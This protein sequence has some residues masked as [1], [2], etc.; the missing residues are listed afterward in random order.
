[1][2][3]PP[4]AAAA[5]PPAPA[6]G[7]V[8]VM[9]LGSE[10]AGAA[11]SRGGSLESELGGV[12]DLS[13]GIMSASE[14]S[15]D[16]TQF[17]LDAT[18][19]ARIASAAYDT[20][21]PPGL[22]L[23]PV[24]TGAV[25]D[26][27]QAAVRRADAA[28]QL[29]R[30]GLLAGHLAG[31]AAYAGTTV[32]DDLDGVL[33]ADRSGRVAALSLGSAATLPGRVRRLGTEHG[34]VVGDL[35]AGAL[36]LAELRAMLAARP[37]EELVIV[38]QRAREGSGRELLWVAAAGLPG[39]GG[40]EL[41]SA[42]TDQRGLVTSIDLAPTIL[43][44]LGVARPADIRGAPIRTDGPLHAAGLGDLMARLQVI[45]GRR[46]RALGCLLAAWAL[47]LLACA[48]W[49]SRRRRAVAW[50]L[51]AGAL[52]V[53]WVPAAAL[54]T[55]ALEPGAALEYTLIALV[56]LSLGAATDAL[57]PWPR[58][59]LGPT[60]VTV[61]ALL[62]DA[63]LRTQLLV[64]SLLGPDPI[65]G[66]RFYGFGNELKSALAVLVFAAVAA[67][68][69]PIAQEAGPRR[70]RRAAATMAGAGILLAA[71]VGSA[72]VG[73]G[74]GGVILVCAGT[75]VAAV[76]LLPGASTRRR[77][78]I[79]LISPLVGLVA[80]AALDLATAHGSGHFTGSVLHARSA[81]DLRDILVR[82]YSAAWRELKNHAMPLATAL[83]LLCAVLGTRHRARLLA[84]VQADRGW[85]AAF[86]GGLAAGVVGAFS[87]DSGPVLF[88]VAVFT[89]ACVAAYLWGGPA[90]ARRDGRA[91]GV[92]QSSSLRR[93]RFTSRTTATM[94]ITASRTPP[95]M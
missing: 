50:A 41:T 2:P 90:G 92:R 42:T 64:R 4:S 49:P 39:G 78:L 60:V 15:Y 61:L 72:R 71:I 10:G 89:L 47:V 56:C 86:A 21:H 93:R 70:L 51:R 63:L 16:R 26:G 1:M 6:G 44:R 40:R 80:L 79:V 87:E 77:M 94:T 66:A 13:I 73:A 12:P 8:L 43:A 34:L 3:C 53:L 74:V 38:V 37:A 14:G 29:L 5:S 23:V 52:G 30:P 84:P 75:A 95:T 69:Y 48:L 57:L 46:L 31:G 9:F 27:W 18:Q 45:S 54:L 36:G 91:R 68:L 82:R 35:P 7:R 62:G 59:P 32:T 24:A 88:V 55:A 11:R 67:A 81:G 76:M 22:A 17:L 83:A 20:S 19:G 25:V 85:S 33:A 65:L 28:P 58:A